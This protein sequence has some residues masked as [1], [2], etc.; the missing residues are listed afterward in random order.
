MNLEMDLANVNHVH[1]DFIAQSVLSNHWN[2][3][4]VIIARVNRLNLNNVHLV[5][6]V[7]LQ[8]FNQVISVQF[9][10]QEDI[11]KME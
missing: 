1:Q 8:N 4:L 6:M 5:N 11:V 7:K 2:A 3:L 9:A 10:Q